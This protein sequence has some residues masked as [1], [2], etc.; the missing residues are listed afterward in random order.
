M[1]V[2]LLGGTAEAVEAAAAL[3]ALGHAVTTS[4]AGRTREP[5]PVAGGVRVGGFGGVEGLAAHLEAERVDLLIDATHPFAGTISVNAAE[6]S[7]RAGVPRVAL[8][9]PA[10]DRVPG[11]DWRAVPDVAAAARA[12][13]PG[14]RAL[15][16]LGRQHLA[17]F[18]ARADVAMVARAI[19]PPDLP[20]EAT[21]I[22]ARPSADAGEERA[23]LEAHRVSHLVSRNS[24]GLGAYAKIAAARALRLP[25]VMIDRPPAPP[26]PRV[27][28]VEALLRAL[29][30]LAPVA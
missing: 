9:R 11:D 22:L 7:A 23:M 27:D 3:D 29:R 4:L 1:R 17:P 2:L 8:H 14:A 28:S 20:F 18:G 16:A 25:V 26:P 21:V 19:E 30:L 15:L 12:L 10:W 5:R 13:P 6:A 24:G